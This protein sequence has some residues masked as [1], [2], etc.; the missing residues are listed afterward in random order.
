LKVTEINEN[1]E[2][3]LHKRLESFAQLFRQETD[4]APISESDMLFIQKPPLPIVLGSTVPSISVAYNTSSEQWI[5][6]DQLL[7][8]T[9]DVVLANNEQDKL[10]LTE[11]FAKHNLQLTIIL[12][13]E[14]SNQS[15]FISGRT[16]IKTIDTAKDVNGANS[17]AVSMFSLIGA[18]LMALFIIVKI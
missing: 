9:V 10:E 18:S 6:D 5:N 12:K 7:G 14:L 13:A 11:W 8:S 4:I 1:V 17:I 15:T 3:V 16:K 2:E